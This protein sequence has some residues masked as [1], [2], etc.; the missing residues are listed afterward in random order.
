[1][2]TK[3]LIA[4]PAL[5]SLLALPVLANCGAVKN[6]PGV[7]EL[8]GGNCPD[9]NDPS[10]ILAFDFQ[11]EF[12]LQLDAAAK[13]KAGAAAAAQINMF[14]ASIDS[15]LKAGCTGLAKD[16]GVTGDFKNAEEA[17]RAAIGGMNAMKSKFGATAK[18]TLVAE[19]PVCEASLS[20][21]ADC[22]AKCDAS[23]TPGKAE[24][25]CEPGH[26][27]GK[28]DASC[29]GSCQMNASAVCNGSCHGTCDAQIKGKC[30]GTC[31]GKCDGK[32]SNGSCAGTCEGTCDAQVDASCSGKCGGTCE[33]KGEA[34][35]EGTCSGSCSVDMKAPQ[36]TGKVTPPKMSAECKAHCDAQVSAKAQC[37]PAKVSVAIVGAVDTKAAAQ[38]RLALENNLPVVMKLAVGMKERALDVAASGQ[39]VIAGVQGTVQAAGASA[40]KVGACFGQSF[41]AALTSVASIKAEVNVSVE[42][43]ASA[44][45]SGSAS[46]STR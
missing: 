43:H 25:Q 4:F 27:S 3:H 26:L 18:I 28:C 11:R 21:T 6:L 7:S 24:V 10:A 8:P 17:C 20:A 12:Q 31:K 29:K 37:R 40:V 34:K 22:A 1:M 19:P 41:K 46:G 5:L 2:N 13:I 30:G 32:N 9:A 35:C 33:I 36:C 39:D 38:Y 15:D 23:I 42:V 45:A 14:A 16:L 44:S